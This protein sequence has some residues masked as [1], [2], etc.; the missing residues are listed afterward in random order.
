MAFEKLVGHLLN[1][2]ESELM[3]ELGSKMQVGK[4]L[5]YRLYLDQREIDEI[6]KENFQSRKERMGFAEKATLA[7]SQFTG[8]EKRRKQHVI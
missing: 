8:R 4:W 2:Q 5:A 6:T 3:S 7:R 1:K